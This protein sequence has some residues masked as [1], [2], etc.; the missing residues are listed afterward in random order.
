MDDRIIHNPHLEVM[1]D[2]AGPHYVVLRNTL[3]Q[4]G[5]TAEQAAQALDNSWTQNHMARVQ[6]WEQQ[7]AEDA[8]AEEAQRQQQLQVAQEQAAQLAADQERE[9]AEMEKK[10][11][12]MKDFDDAVTVGSYCTSPQGQLSMPSSG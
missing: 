2:H 1:P 4:N 11:P 12:K 10:K 5:M 6:A 8:A 3:T 9:R 7:V